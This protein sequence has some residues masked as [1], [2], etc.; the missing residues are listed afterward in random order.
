MSLNEDVAFR[1]LC[2]VTV[3]VFVVSGTSQFMY[4]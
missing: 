4:T 3:V 2:V 1:S